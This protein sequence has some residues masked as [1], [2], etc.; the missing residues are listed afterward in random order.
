VEV[1]PAGAHRWAEQGA[2]TQKCGP[3]H[4]DS[5][6]WNV[7]WGAALC[8]EWFNCMGTEWEQGGR[9]IHRQLSFGEAEENQEGRQAR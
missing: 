8:S 2:V 6:G 3:W 9:L 5:C 7:E 4:G 1:Q